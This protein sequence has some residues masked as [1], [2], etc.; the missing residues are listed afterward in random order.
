MAFITVR[1]GRRAVERQQV[2]PIAKTDVGLPN[3][4]NV[5]QMPLSYLD[6]DPTLAGNSDEK[7]SSQAAVKAYVDA[8]SGELLTNGNASSPELIFADGDVIVCD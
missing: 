1:K 4:A 3:V 8:R 7:V 5:E 6:T 2:A